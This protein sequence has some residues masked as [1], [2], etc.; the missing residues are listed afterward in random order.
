MVSWRGGGRPQSTMG[1]P[2]RQGHRQCRW[3]YGRRG[4]C[5]PHRG[6]RGEEHVPGEGGNDIYGLSFDKCKKIGV[7]IIT[8][9]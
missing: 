1:R 9:D 3:A 4:A 5:G 8:C 6:T 7:N 2:H